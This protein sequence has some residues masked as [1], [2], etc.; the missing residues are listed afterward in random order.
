MAIIII[1]H[2]SSWCFRRASECAVWLIKANYSFKHFV[3][4]NNCYKVFA[5]AIARV[6]PI[7]NITLRSSSLPIFFPHKIFILDTHV[8]LI[9]FH[10][11]SYPSL[12][13]RLGALNVLKRNFFEFWKHICSFSH[14][15]KLRHVSCFE[16]DQWIFLLLSSAG[17][18]RM[19]EK[20][21]KT[22]KLSQKLLKL[23]NSLMKNIARWLSR[24]KTTLVHWHRQPS[25]L[26]HDADFSNLRF[27]ARLSGHK[28]L[29]QLASY[30][31]PSA[32]TFWV[33]LSQHSI[34]WIPKNL[35]ELQQAARHF[36]KKVEN[37]RRE[38]REKWK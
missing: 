5:C 29:H 3:I 6:D 23:R 4:A 37:P 13:S 14:D 31:H 38:A 20:A 21:K 11:F 35:W 9:E 27:F 19:K 7:P 25:R 22:K 10:S 17:E 34:I 30:S 8:I 33:S 32:F 1:T 2:S 18:C 36:G 28:L 15:E 16:S 12:L 24:L 26:S